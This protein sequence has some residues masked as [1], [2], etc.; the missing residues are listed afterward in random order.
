MTMKR[1]DT[2]TA[3]TA[4]LK[5][6]KGN[7]LDLTGAS[8]TFVMKRYHNGV[9]LIDREAT[10]LEAENGRVCHVFTEEEAD[11]LGVMKCVFRVTHIDGSIET[12]PNQ[13]YIIIDFES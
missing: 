2:R 13:G 8:V 10:I 11:V 7:P 9:V 3:P 1:G 6:P 12:F 4:K 5:T